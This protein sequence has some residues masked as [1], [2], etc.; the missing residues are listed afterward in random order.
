MPA[1]GQEPQKGGW[2]E[3][4]ETASQGEWEHADIS[5]IGDQSSD[6]H[7]VAQLSPQTANFIEQSGDPQRPAE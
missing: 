5:K 2:C 6:P 4:E 3:L 7:R 1:K